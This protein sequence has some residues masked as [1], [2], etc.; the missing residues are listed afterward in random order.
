MPLDFSKPV[1]ALAPLA[2]FTDLPF[3]SVV[4]Q[5][6]VDLTVSEM[7]SSNALAYGSDKTEK[8]L[9]K[10]P[11]EMPYSIQIAGS[12]PEIIK[13]AVEV[14]NARE[15]VDI[16][17]LNAGCP[18][19]K[20]VNNLQGSALLTDLDRLGR[21]IE[22]IRSYSDKPMTS[23]K[24]RLG[25]TEKI[26]QQIAR[27][28]EEAGADFIAVHGRTRS[29][30]Y[31]APVD[32]DAIAEVKAAVSIPVLANGDIDSPAKAR[33]VL[34]HTGCDGVM[35]GRAAVGNP[36]IFA[37]IRDGID[38]VTPALITEVV[39][40]HFDQMIAHYGAYGVI[41]FRKH[42]HTYSKAGYP[43]A[44][45]FRHAVNTVTD[46]AAMRAE[47]ERFFAQPLLEGSREAIPETPA[48]IVCMHE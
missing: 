28:C 19:P 31:K 17:D 47:V 18:V 32:Y 1:Y 14:I 7:I 37:Q 13:R 20:V 34:E 42:L 27:V 40:K 43:G 35:I 12:D 11:L 36:W 45:A 29:G 30:K 15:G 41:L 48:A 10:S 9:E 44:G 2:G 8:M 24:I 46:P 4:K 39:L 38:A 3:R 6:G 25:Y 16:I 23:V 33:W 22:T 21:A 5:F 26:H